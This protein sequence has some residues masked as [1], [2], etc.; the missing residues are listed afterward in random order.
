MSVHKVAQDVEAD[1]K[2]LGPFSFRQFIYLIIAV[3]S[4]GLAWGLSNIFAPLAILPI[5]LII[6]F[7]ALSLPLKKDQPM[8]TYLAAIV[9]FYLKPRKKTWQ[10]N[11][12]EKTVEI[13]TP[14]ES[15]TK[16]TKDITWD[17]ADRRFS[18]LADIVDSHGWSI[19]N[20]ASP[21]NQTSMVQDIF[22]E[23]QN[24]QDM[25]DSGSV[26]ANQFDSMISD[27]DQR[28][29]DNLIKK[30]QNPQLIP[31]TP[32]LPPLNNSM[33]SA[34]RPD[35][36]SLRDQALS[37][38]KTQSLVSSQA[39]KTASPNPPSADI[40]S[41]ANDKDLSIEAIEREAN[42]RAKNKDEVF[43]SLH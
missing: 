3:I 5:P 31:T 22:D 37:V 15:E 43:I 13:T 7:G 40:I 28:M 41:L 23:A 10:Q 19:R 36:G 14:E 34:T 25:L 30:M 16:L 42:R 20:S 38:A 27:S 32:P 26:M 24:T 35:I 11:S 4:I 9:S 29:R 18:Y 1:D 33:Q 21:S 2:I 12:E 6:F 17:E 39:T 8:E